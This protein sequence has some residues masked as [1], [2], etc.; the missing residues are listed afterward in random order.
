M[1]FIMPYLLYL[2]LYVC[3]GVYLY[4]FHPVLPLQIK[5]SNFGLSR[6]VGMT[7]DYYRSTDGSTKLPVAWFVA[8][9]ASSIRSLSI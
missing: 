2:C 5:I 8:L 1:S 3:I 4:P 6:A 7:R 9:L